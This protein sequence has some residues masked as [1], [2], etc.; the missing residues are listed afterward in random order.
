MSFIPHKSEPFNRNPQTLV[1][2]GHRILLA[3]LMALT[4]SATTFTTASAQDLRGPLLNSSAPYSPLETPSTQMIP[5]SVPTAKM[6]APQNPLTLSATLNA[7]FTQN[8]R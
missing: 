6:T 5:F 8:P 1:F 2:S 7:S 4:V 3:C